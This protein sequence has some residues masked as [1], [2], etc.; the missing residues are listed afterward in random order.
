MNSIACKAVHD[1]TKTDGF[2]YILDA[3]KFRQSDD[4]RERALFML[5]H[6]LKPQYKENK[7]GLILFLQS[8]YSY[9]SGVKLSAKDIRNK[10]NY[11]WNKDYKIGIHYLNNLL[12][13]LGIEKPQTI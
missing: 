11:H 10:V 6:C 1:I 9:S 8:W 2:K 7:E 5:I 3:V 12:E 13:S 4:G